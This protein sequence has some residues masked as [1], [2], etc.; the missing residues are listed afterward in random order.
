MEKLVEHCTSDTK[1]LG[2][3]PIRLPKS[4]VEKK[5]LLGHERILICGFPEPIGFKYHGLDTHVL[6]FQLSLEIHFGGV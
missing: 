2:S 3:I 1:V 6:G 5:H 4:L